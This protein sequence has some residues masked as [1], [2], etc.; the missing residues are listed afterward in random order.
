[1]FNVR[2]DDRDFS[3]LIRN[4]NNLTPAQIFGLISK[5]ARVGLVKSRVRQ[6]VIA[7]APKRAGT[8]KAQISRVRQRRRSRGKPPGAG[9]D[10]GDTPR[11]AIAGNVYE[12]GRK[13]GK[14]PQ[15]ARPFIRPILDREDANI[16]RAMETDIA[17]SVE[18]RLAR[19]LKRNPR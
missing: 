11:V 7:A 6:Q 8:L 15:P 2:I 14:A 9:F 4:L 5:G 10:I 17:D 18:K 1:M 19:N 12:Y 3:T 16:R 13:A